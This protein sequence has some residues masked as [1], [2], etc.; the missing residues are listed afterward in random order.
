M[1]AEVEIRNVIF[2]AGRGTVVVGHTRSGVAQAGQVSAAMAL[3]EDPP[4]RL[5]VSVVEHLSSMEGRA[6]AVG[7]VFRDPPNL[8]DL[9]RALPPGSLLALEDPP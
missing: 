8:N 3:G 5:E 1:R 9:K 7:I 4:R 6:Q 2:L